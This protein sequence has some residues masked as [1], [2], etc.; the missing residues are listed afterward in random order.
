[1]RVGCRRWQEWA[2]VTTMSDWPICPPPPP[3]RAQCCRGSWRAPPGQRPFGSGLSAPCM[4]GRWGCR[5]AAA[6][7]CVPA[8]RPCSLPLLLVAFH[9]RWAVIGPVLIAGP[10]TSPISPG[11][12]HAPSA[13]PIRG[14]C[15]LVG[16]AALVLAGPILSWPGGGWVCGC[17]F[18]P[19]CS[20]R[21]LLWGSPWLASSL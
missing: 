8:L 13:H 2:W 16:L 6:P 9:L 7:A 4:G 5:S 1:V 10:L 18:V 15:F 3:P 14:C 19:A 20:A 17:P 21:G 12:P 11:V